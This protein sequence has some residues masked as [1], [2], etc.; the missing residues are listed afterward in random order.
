[1]TKAIRITNYGGPEVLRLQSLDLPKPGP[2]QALVQVSA[3]G[4]NFMD[5]GVRNGMYRHDGAPPFTPG[6]EGSGRIVALGEGASK[7]KVGDR[8][9]WFYSPG[10]YAEQIVAPVDALVPLPDAI[11][12]LTGAAILMQGLLPVIL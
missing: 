4:V 12:D 9:A 11:D 6:V 8:V 1:M 7:L 3:A 10:S 5:V 2:G